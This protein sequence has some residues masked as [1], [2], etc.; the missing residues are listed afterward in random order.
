[1]QNPAVSGD[2]LVGELVKEL[3]V[4][5]GRGVQVVGEPR[6]LGLRLLRR[7]VEAA[8]LVE[9][10]RAGG[11]FVDDFALGSADGLDL[12]EL[13]AALGLVALLARVAQRPERVAR[14]ALGEPHLREEAVVQEQFHGLH[15]VEEAQVFRVDHHVLQL[16]RLAAHW[17]LEEPER[18]LLFVNR[19]DYC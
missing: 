12:G 10:E 3:V 14:V 13:P 6:D 18:L 15:V 19:L 17:V 5:M 9:V 4:G 8:Q 7:E 16:V 11:G 2:Y 1:M